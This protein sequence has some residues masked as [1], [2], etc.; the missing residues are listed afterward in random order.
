MQ[1]T[2]RILSKLILCWTL[3]GD[4]NSPAIAIN[5]RFLNYQKIKNNNN[6]II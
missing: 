1:Y 6:N 2:S 5:E 4:L 3:H